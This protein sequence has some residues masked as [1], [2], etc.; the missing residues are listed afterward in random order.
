MFE[1]ESMNRMDDALALFGD[2]C[3]Y[4]LKSGTKLIGMRQKTSLQKITKMCSCLQQARFVPRKDK[5]CTPYRVSGVQR[6]K[7]VSK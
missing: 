2:I 7:R 5:Q 1:N 4:H 6:Y 3:K